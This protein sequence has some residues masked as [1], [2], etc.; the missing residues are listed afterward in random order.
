ML[1]QLALVGKTSWFAMKKTGPASVGSSSWGL[2]GAASVQQVALVDK[3]EK[4][5]V[6]VPEQAEAFA[7]SFGMKTLAGN[8]S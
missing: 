6:G 3:T 4:A 2:L 7:A 8:P 1:E 5:V